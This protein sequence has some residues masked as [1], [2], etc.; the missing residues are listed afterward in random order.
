MAELAELIIKIKADASGLEREL[1]K[2][3]QATATAAT[4]M[5]RSMNSV[6]SSFRAL[7]PALGVGALVAFGRSAFNAADRLNDLS[8][9]TGILGSTLSALNIPLLQSGSNVEEFSASI[10]RMNNMIGEASKGLSQDAVNAFDVLGLS[11]LKLKA[12]SPEQQFFE[13]A[14][15]LGKMENQADMTNAGMAIFGRS[16]ASL[17][18]LIKDSKGNLAEFIAKIKEADGALSE[19]ELSK[20]NEFGD[21][22]TFALERMKLAAVGVLLVLMDI[23]KIAA[24][25]PNTSGMLSLAR[26]GNVPTNEAFGPA[27]QKEQFGPNFPKVSSEQFGPAFIPKTAKGSNEGLVKDKATDSVVKKANEELRAAA[28]ETADALDDQTKATNK[29]NDAAER[30]R[31]ELSNR[32]SS[33][34]TQAV[35]TANSAGEAFRNL[36]VQIAQSIFEQNIAKPISNA[37]VSIGSSILGGFDFSSFLPSF[38]V[39]SQNVPNDMIA[40]IHKGEMI[41][42][43][44][45]AAKI[46]NGGG[47]ITIV[48]N[49][50]FQSGVTRQEIFNI[51]PSVAKAAH[52]A[53]FST[54]KN[55]GS[56]AKA[57]GI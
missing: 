12:L 38:A 28:K 10:N 27:F 30:F 23:G 16:F 47:G 54:I 3:G 22:W 1:K 19:A 14:D 53:V 36:G 39:G 5:Q 17:I 2:A 40:K 43:A 52:D 8:Q 35:F 15:A 26:M 33:S 7:I 18:P 42:P 49:N 25:P 4:G 44:N 31:E 50:S 20:I 51:L 9:R 45:D 37:A 41:V 24:T 56:M 6:A 21:R 55:G 32:L 29:A 11:V 46:R 57:A 48:Q 34:L 13:I